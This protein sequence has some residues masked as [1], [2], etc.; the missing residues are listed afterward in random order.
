MYGV[1]PELSGEITQRLARFVERTPDRA[2][3]HFYYAMS[4]WKGV[5]QVDHR[6]AS[7]R[8]CGARSPSTADTPG[9]ACSSASCS[10]SSAAGPTRSRS[11]SGPSRS[12]PSSRKAHFR[13]AHAY[14]RNGQTALADEELAIFERLKAREPA[15]APPPVPE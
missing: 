8:S 11:C 4:L 6:L 14:R 2:T 1:S 12:P 13:L 10:R 15:D 5:G 7:R 3:G 9:R